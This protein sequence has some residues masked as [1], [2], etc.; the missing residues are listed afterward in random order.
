MNDFT[1][2][3]ADCDHVGA[4]YEL[5]METMHDGR[6]DVVIPIPLPLA[7]DFVRKGT[8]TSPGFKTYVMS[9]LSS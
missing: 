4:V 2:Y 5:H 1:F 9:V 3:C 8:P 6:R 7:V